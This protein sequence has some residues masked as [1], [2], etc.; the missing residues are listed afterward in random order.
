VKSRCVPVKVPRIEEKILTEALIRRHQLDPGRAADVVR[1]AAGNYLRALDLISE[2]EDFRYNFNKFRDLMR[3]CFKTNIAELVK[4]AELLATLNREK[5]KSFLEYGLRTLRESLALH[6]STPDIVFISDEEKEF[7]PNFAPYVNGRNIEA[8][9][10]E[11][12]KAIQDIERNGN[13]RIVILDM[14]LKLAALIKN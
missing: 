12:T 7:T 8:L 11:I 4:Q 3:S 5:Q 14:A 10:G 2:T 6:F 13:S 1:L 9:M